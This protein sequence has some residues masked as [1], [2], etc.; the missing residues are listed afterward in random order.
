MLFFCFYN[1]SLSNSDVSVCMLCLALVSDQP[2]CGNQI[3]EDGEECDVGHNDT[4]PCCYSAKESLAVQCRL[5]PNKICRYGTPFLI[6]RVLNTFFTF[7][8]LATL[9]LLFTF[10]LSEVLEM[11]LQVS[12]WS[13]S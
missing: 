1:S 12:N 6:T 4:D 8:L 3:M 10:R 2:I 11:P 13:N 7:V 9:V 5:K